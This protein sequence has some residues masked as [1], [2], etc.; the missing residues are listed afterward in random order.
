MLQTMKLNQHNGAVDSDQ[1]PT[2]RMSDDGGQSVATSF[3]SFERL[4]SGLKSIFGGKS[5]TGVPIT[6]VSRA[7]NIYASTFASEVVTC[8]F[9]DGSISKLFCK[10]G[11][12][13]FTDS[14]ALRGVPYE[15]YIYRNVL[16]QLPLTTPRFYG[17]YEDEATGQTCL[18]LEYLDAY[19]RVN[20]SYGPD[21]MKLTAH[22][23]GRF[24]AA[25]E[26]LPV[27]AW[28]S[29]LN[30]YN[31][32]YLFEWK[33]RMADIPN[34]FM[35]KF[36]WLA[37]MCDRCDEFLEILLQATQTIIHGE[38][39]PS[40]ALIRDGEICVV[41]WE[42][43]GIGSGEL[44]LAA[45]TQGPWP[46]EIIQEC[47][48]AYRKARWCTSAPLSFGRIFC[49]AKLYFYFRLLFHWLRFYPNQARQEVWLFDHMFSAGEQLGII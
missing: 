24:H 6:V 38:F 47:E 3:P 37:D 49:A 5:S 30:S 18:V 26:K 13:Y 34:H 20:K 1:A 21:A 33:R 4:V 8:R 31:A 25:G 41:D 2:S 9:V 16:T 45:L 19:L 11:S 14:T 35:Q 42:S 46:E 17:T 7:P 27:S 12:G 48:A 10:Y 36:Q 44:D 28:T 15:A 29:N 40:N 39:Y 32:K 43:A 22:W 23:I